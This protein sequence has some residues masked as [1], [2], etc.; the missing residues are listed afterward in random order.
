MSFVDWT[1]NGFAMDLLNTIPTTHNQTRLLRQ[2]TKTLGLTMDLQWIY[3]NPYLQPII[4]KI[5]IGLLR[6][7]TKIRKFTLDFLWMYNSIPLLQ[8]IIKRISIG[9][10][11]K[12]IEI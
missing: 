12:P 6:K 11:R 2:P 7:P 5:S 9:L 4:K 10:P 8:P 3:S 1:P